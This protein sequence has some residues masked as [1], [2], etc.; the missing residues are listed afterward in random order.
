MLVLFLLH[1][2]M[3]SILYVGEFALNIVNSLRFD[4]ISQ[5]RAVSFEDII[6][7]RICLAFLINSGTKFFLYSLFFWFLTAL[8]IKFFLT[9][10]K[11]MFTI[12]F[13]VVISPLITV[14][15]PIDKLGNGKAEAFEMWY[16]ELV[17]NVIIQPIHAII[18]L[19]FIYT[20]G[21]IA[22]K[23]PWVA[24]VFLLSLGRVENIIRNI[25]KITDSVD[26]VNSARKGGGHKGGLGG[27]IKNFFSK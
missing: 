2:I 17:L 22:Q 21:K 27:L 10:I 20:A 11:R 3:Y 23:A 26:N 19:I 7:D 25:F 1:Y 14:T 15:Y 16:K 6:I 13:L 24:M 9:Y 8:H 5:G 4:A 12:F 18:Y